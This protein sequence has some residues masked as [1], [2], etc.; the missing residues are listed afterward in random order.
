MYQDMGNHDAAVADFTSA[1]GCQDGGETHSLSYF[2]RGKS[3]LEQAKMLTASKRLAKLDEAF[4]DFN[5]S[6]THDTGS[7]AGI[8]DGLGTYFSLKR[9]TV[10]VLDK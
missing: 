1:I 10:L 8:D 4:A 7:N 3:Y 9:E 6:R 5:K 2:N